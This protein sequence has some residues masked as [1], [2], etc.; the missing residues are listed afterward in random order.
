MECKS[1]E[2]V[3]YNAGWPRIFEHEAAAIKEQLDG[4][5]VEIHHV[6]STAVLG[7]SAKPIIDMVLVAKNPSKAICLL[8]SLGYVYEGE[9]N[10]PFRFY[11]NKKSTIEFHLHVYSPDSPE[12]EL[13]LLF[14]NFLRS[15]PNP[16]NE[17]AELKRALAEEQKVYKDVQP[18]FSHYTLGKNIFIRNILQQTGFD[19]LRLMHCTHYAEWETAEIY[20]QKYFF[21]KVP[22]ADPYTWTFEHKDHVH[23]VLYKGVEI[24]GY[25]HLQCWPEQRVAMRIIVID[26]NFRGQGFGG[27][28]LALCEKWLRQQKVKS[29]HVEASPQAVGFYKHCKYVEIPFDDPDNHPSDL[30]DVEL[31]KIL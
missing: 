16:C 28:L 22:I 13:N 27:Y 31:G 14:R 24:I 12:I 6:G 29:L 2:I 18:M 11:F 25:V 10:I 23:F 15:H 20:R 30:Q 5:C 3:P 21:D 8:E 9:M 26:E 17:Y 7:L 19:K 4:N 1:I